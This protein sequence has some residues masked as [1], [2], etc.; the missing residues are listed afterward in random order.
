MTTDDATATA[1]RAHAAAEWAALRDRLRTITPQAIGRG[2]LTLGAIAGT[3]WL[4][5]A[6]WPALLPFVIGGLLAYQL[7]PV[8]DA[9]DRVLPRSLAALV[10]V[11]AAVAVVVAIGV[12]VL[13]PLANAFVRLAGDLPTTAEV[14]D[15]IARLQRQLGSSRR[16]RGG[17]DPGRHR[18]SRRRSGT[19]SPG[20]AGGLDD[21]V[22][23]GLAALLNA[24]GALLGLIVLPT[25]M[26]VL[27][28]HKERARIAIDA[29][30]TPGLRGDVWAAAAIVDR[31]A[32]SYLRGYVVAAFLVGLL[33]YIG[34]RGVSPSRRAAVPGAAR[35]RD[36]GRRD[37]GRARGRRRSSA[38]LPA[39]LLLAIEPER[40]AATYFAVY[41]GA[42]IIGGARPGLAADGRRLGVHPA[43]LVPGVVMIG[44]FGILRLLLSAPIV[45][46][47][48]DLVRYVHGRLSEPPRAG[49]RPAPDAGGDAD[50]QSRRDR[51]P[52]RPIRLPRGHRR[53]RR[54]SR[55]PRRRQPAGGERQH[56]DMTGGMT[57]DGR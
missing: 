52:T 15:A 21:I 47:A 11:L 37:P 23:A 1:R 4:A 3:V 34:R 12:I 33:T 44:Q 49:R 46:I 54:S 14:D 51:P 39:L 17:R 50:R 38:L 2:A 26:L 30:I 28:S 5:A 42:R 7:L 55:R 18:R 9:L 53:R 19:S 13:P 22:R 56:H 27:M 20:A 57:R 29:R 45:A 36:A 10:S 25:W 8:V 41:L 48:V 35:A 43:I 6:S 24:F 16:A 32:G 31:A 40:A